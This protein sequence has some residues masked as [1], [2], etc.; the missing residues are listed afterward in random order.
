MNHETKEPRRPSISVS[1]PD[2]G[3]IPFPSH[4][5]NRSRSSSQVITPAVGKTKEEVKRQYS[6]SVSS[7]GSDM[8]DGLGTN[9]PY[10]NRNRKLSEVDLENQLILTA[11]GSREDV[12]C[13]FIK[14]FVLMILV[15]G[16]GVLIFYAL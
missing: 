16:S 4:K 12:C 3:P 7:V 14:L 11:G 6:Y 5:P 15:I 9:N 1:Q 8:D 10:A 2:S 13:F